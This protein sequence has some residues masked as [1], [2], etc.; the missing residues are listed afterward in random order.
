MERLLGPFIAILISLGAAGL[1]G[2]SIDA[3]STRVS[4]GSAVRL[5]L[6]DVVVLIRSLPKQRN[7]LKFLI[8]RTVY[9]D[10]LHTLIKLEGIY[11]SG[12]MGW[13]AFD[14]LAFAIV[15]IVFASCGGLL[16]GILN[17]RIGTRR[18]LILE[19]CCTIVLLVMVLGTTPKTLLFFWAYDASAHAALWSGPVFRTLPELA[20]LLI[21]ASMTAF[22]VATVASGRAMVVEIVA[23]D[24]LGSFFGLF[25]VS[26]SATAWIAPALIGFFTAYFHSQSIGLIPVAVLLAIGAATLLFVEGGDRHGAPVKSAI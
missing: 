13:H 21:S 20:F 10:G 6:K 8:A 23:P 18:A 22:A 9:G 26:A 11:A 12:V 4:L 25:H 7:I 1:L 16:A 24:R 15:K 17:V 3:P 5:G 19:L 14:L 2:F